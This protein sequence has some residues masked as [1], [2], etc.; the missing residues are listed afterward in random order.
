MAKAGDE[1]EKFRRTGL[2][3]RR[4]GAGFEVEQVLQTFFVFAQG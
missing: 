3:G 1:I 2:G 4:G